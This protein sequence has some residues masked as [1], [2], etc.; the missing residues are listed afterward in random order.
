M[1]FCLFQTAFEDECDILNE[2]D[3]EPVSIRLFQTGLRVLL[4]AQ[5]RRQCDIVPIT[6][7]DP[8]ELNDLRDILAALMIEQR[9]A[10][11]HE[12]RLA[13]DAVAAAASQFTNITYRDSVFLWLTIQGY[14]AET[15]ALAHSANEKESF[16]P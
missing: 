3:G 5:M 16:F 6:D 15:E 4:P 14:V 9:E 7:S 8:P 13:R 12:K 10:R 2:A 1:P 11:P